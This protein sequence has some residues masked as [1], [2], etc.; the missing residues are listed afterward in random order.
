MILNA[1]LIIFT[2][3]SKTDTSSAGEQLVRDKIG[4]DEQVKVERQSLPLFLFG[5]FRSVMPLK[6][7]R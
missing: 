1:V 4:T 2:G 7:R 6:T 3:Q 5:M